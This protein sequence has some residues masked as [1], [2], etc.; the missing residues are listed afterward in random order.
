VRRIV[1][2]GVVALVAFGLITARFFVWPSADSP[3]AADA[4]VLFA[5]G[6]GERLALA[7]QLMARKLAAHLVIPNGTVPEWPAGNRA[8]TD[9]RPYE[10]HCPTPE[11]DTTRGEARAIAA[12]AER[13]G[14]TRLLVVTSSYQLVR[15][16]LLLGRCFEGEIRRVR[17]Q[18]ALSAL[19]WLQRVRHE[20]LAWAHAM[21]VERGC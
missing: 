3:E 5:G 15:A 17:A 11:P 18:P 14:W 4:V 19:D 7:E 16:G 2:V 9:D 13:N 20:W 1:V 10:V 6:R 12:L 8:C 21:T